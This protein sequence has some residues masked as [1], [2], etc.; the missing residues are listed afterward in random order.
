MISQFKETYMQNKKQL[1]IDVNTMSKALGINKNT[2]K[3][4][5]EIEILSPKKTV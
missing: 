2:L 4:W 3:V 1:Q 5:D